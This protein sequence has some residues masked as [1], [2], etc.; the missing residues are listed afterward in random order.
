MKA[1]LNLEEW[2][3]FLLCIY[4]FSRLP[5]AWWWFPALILLP[6]VGMLGYLINPEI[7]AWT[8]NLLHHRAVAAVVAVI[9]LWLA[10]PAWQLAALILFAHISMDRAMGYGLK[11]TDSFQNTHLGILPSPKHK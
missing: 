1:L 4:L 11:F 3:V 8:Y 10:S 9:G 2:A 6:D 7:G 5:F